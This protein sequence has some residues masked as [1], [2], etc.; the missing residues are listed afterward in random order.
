[1]MSPLLAGATLRAVCW[2]LCHGR[3]ISGQLFFCPFLFVKEMGTSAK[4]LQQ[5]FVRL[6]NPRQIHAGMTEDV[7]SRKTLAI[8]FLH[9]TRQAILS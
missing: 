1:M 3:L 6:L 8:T 7:G 5:G 2:R 4:G 9:Y